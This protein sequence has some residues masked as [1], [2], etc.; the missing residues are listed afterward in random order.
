MN[1]EVES[2]ISSAPEF[3]RLEQ[4]P[5]I[6]QNGKLREHQLAGVNWLISLYELGV[7]GILAD[8]M[9]LGKTIQAISF[10]GYLAESK[11]IRGH[12]LIVCPNSV[13]GN[14]MKE[15]KKWLPMVKV[16]KLI[17]RKE[18]RL[19]IFEKYI[20]TKNFDVC[21]TS[22]EGVNVCKSA[23][24]KIHWEY[25]VVD[26]AHRLKN[27]ESLLSRNLREFKSNSKLL[28]TGT[29]LQNN[30][31]ELWSLLNFIMPDLFD[32]PEVFE[33]CFQNTRDASRPET[34]TDQTEG[35]KLTDSNENLDKT[36]AN[37]RE[38][39]LESFI[40][41]LHRILRPFMLKRTK[42]ILAQTLPPKKEIHVL[43]GLTERQVHFYKSI[44]LKRSIMEDVRSSMNVLMQLRKCCNHPYLFNGGDIPDED[45]NG[46][47]LINSS[48]KMIVLDKLLKKLQGNHQ[49]LIFS[50]FT[51]M[52]DII[53]E[54]L[55]IKDYDY[56][57]LDGSTFIDERERQL[58]EFTQPGSKKFVFLLSTRAGGLGINLHSADTVI[59]FDSD[60]NPQIDLQAMD[61]AHRIGQKNT[62]MVYRFITQNTVEEKIIERQKIKLKWDTLVLARGR[63]SAVHDSKGN[64]ISKNELK[65]LINY[66]AS[67]IFKA[68]GGTFKDEDIDFLLARGQ[69]QA[70]QLTKKA[71][72]LIQKAGERLFD[73]GMDSINVYDFIGGDYEKLK[74]EDEL[75]VKMAIE[76]NHKKAKL[77]KRISRFEALNVVDLSSENEAEGRNFTRRSGI[78]LHD[79]QFFTQ[80]E[81]LEELMNKG[82][83]L[84]PE[85]EQE[86][87]AL[88]SQGFISW[89]KKDFKQFVQ[90]IEKFGRD[91]LA[92]ISEYAN[93]SLEDVTAYSKVFWE[94]ISELAES[95]RIL[96]T[97]EKADKGRLSSEPNDQILKNKCEGVSN[98]LDIK[99]NPYLYKRAKSNFYSLS[100]DQF[101]V[102][103][104]YKFGSR[105]TSEIKEAILKE[106]DFR[107]DFNFKGQKNHAI[108]KRLY[109]L[110]RMLSN[111]QELTERQ[112][113]FERSRPVKLSTD[114]MQNDL[115]KDSQE[116]RVTSLN[117]LDIINHFTRKV[118][119]QNTNAISSFENELGARSIDQF[120]SSHIELLNLPKGFSKTD[121]GQNPKT[122]KRVYQLNFAEQFG[123]VHPNPPLA[124]ADST[125]DRLGNKQPTN[126]KSS[127]VFGN[128]RQGSEKSSLNNSKIS[129]TG[130]KLD[131]LKLFEQFWGNM[132]HQPN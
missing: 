5:G 119:V 49:V 106:P 52:L 58:E 100:H 111:E 27:D 105:N 18:F 77:A 90:A 47:H 19:E 38:A 1:S 110:L 97:L 53:E 37:E 102:Y 78:K 129:L 128:G 42:E 29:P 117:R 92:T 48:G 34:S 65:D 123:I 57:R 127:R 12:H 40:V 95:D 6:L 62:V 16:V 112:Q 69:E 107:F 83:D 64:K 56:C 23:L 22:F 82:D 96:K 101:L 89:T 122:E 74:R 72:S 104:A 113:Q 68:E 70:E 2:E 17:A 3:E 86:K 75:A 76:E 35:S 21:L 20:K 91:D 80:R 81:K 11:G 108:L 55:C 8:E 79:H 39:Q 99:F 59:I 41:S 124:K 24:K 109:S 131:R 44:L 46:E 36:V 88:L 103:S 15:F 71:E 13:I 32:S 26:E 28:M 66:G 115:I 31:K 94:R 33:T 87:Q 45:P 61:R 98:Y 51:T 4:Q 132:G 7:N 50:Q 118:S 84:T 14:W 120:K 10:L 43:T 63:F 114:S 130:D 126:E 30:I 54:Y 25:I 125:N 116:S 9:G 85:E 121:P 60:W 73:L 93:K 67:Q